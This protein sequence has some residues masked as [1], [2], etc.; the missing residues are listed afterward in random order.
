[1]KKFWWGGLEHANYGTS[2]EVEENYDNLTNETNNDNNNSSP[3]LEV[4]NKKFKEPCR[5][6]DFI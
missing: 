2:I 1:M 3:I 6:K 5:K 4:K